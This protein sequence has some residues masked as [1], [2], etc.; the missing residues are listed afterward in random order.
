MLQDATRDE[1]YNDVF[2][3]AMAKKKAKNTK[4]VYRKCLIKWTIVT[5]TTG[6]R[7]VSATD[8]LENSHGIGLFNWLSTVCIVQ[9]L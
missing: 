7:V 5:V 1:V 4:D 8:L 9:S 6:E 3:N 2:D